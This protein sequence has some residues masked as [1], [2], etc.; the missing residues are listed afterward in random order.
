MSRDLRSEWHAYVRQELAWC[1][2][3]LNERG[4][5]LDAVQ[6]HTLGERYLMLAARDVGGGGRKLILTGTRVTDGVRVVVKVSRD[7]AG[8]LEIDREHHAR[9][10]VSNLP[11]AYRVFTPPEEL[12]HD[13]TGESCISISR[14]IPQDMA[15]TERP[16]TEQLQLAL[17]MLKLQEAAHAATYE[18]SRQVARVF[19]IERAHGYIAQLKTFARR[20]TETKD[21][22]DALPGLV[23]QVVDACSGSKLRIE[24]YCG[25]LTHADFVPHNF[26]IHDGVPYLLDYASLHFGN[27]YESWARFMNFMMLYNPDLTALLK[28]YVVANRAP[29]E[30]ESL[31]LMRLY[32][33][34]FLL[35]YYAQSLP[36]TDGAQ[37][38]LTRARLSFWGSALTALLE[39]RE[40]PE[41]TV[42]GY[43]SERDALRDE[44]ER[45]RQAQ[46]H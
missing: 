38:A 37:H 19:G 25:F 13:V 15:F 42:R 1:T 30:L 9:K 5:T 4:I 20:V 26:R 45:K 12:L 6:T 39:S 11:F 21:I 44:E 16:L 14:Y 43:I 32:K 36:Q 41:E 17:R 31:H 23:A 24:Q 18:H 29:E 34:T 10:N 27:K 40:L 35:S 46:L 7:Q 3:L 33:L 2:P 8:I 28:Q 22:P